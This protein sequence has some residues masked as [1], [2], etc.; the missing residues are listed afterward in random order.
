LWEGF[1]GVAN[2]VSSDDKA[3]LSLPSGCQVTEADLIVNARVSIDPAELQRLVDKVVK[4]VCTVRAAKQS[5][6]KT[7]SFRPGRPMPTHRYAA[8]K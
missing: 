3:A 7:Q 6:T 4:Q 2:L 1:F 5:E 8:A